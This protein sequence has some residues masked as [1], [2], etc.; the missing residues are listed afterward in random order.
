MPKHIIPTV[1]DGHTEVE[2]AVDDAKAVQEAMDRFHDLVNNQKRMAV[3][4]HPDGTK[5]KISAFD[6]NVDMLFVPQR[7]GGLTNAGR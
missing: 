3:A 1:E 5:S 7:Q 4:V 6:P 2:F